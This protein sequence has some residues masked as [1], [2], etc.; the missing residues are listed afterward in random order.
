M[1]LP[2]PVC[3][4]ENG[5]K[6]PD[7]PCSL[8]CDQCNELHARLKKSIFDNHDCKILFKEMWKHIDVVHW[9]K[10][11]RSHV[12]NGKHLGAWAFTLTKSPSDD[13]SEDDMVR[14]VRKLMSQKSCPVKT[15]AWY[16]EYGDPE[17]KSHPHIHGMYETH[18]GGRI[19]RKHFFRAWNIW[20]ED[21]PLG[22]GFRGGYHREV[23][24]DERYADYIK[25]PEGKFADT[26]KDTNVQ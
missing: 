3:G 7:V 16:L 1:E 21:I 24:H 17:T 10:K 19:E 2:C 15:Y 20:N 6:F 4:V 12:G 25:K 23:K 18:T 11:P 8:C 5:S 22:K 26:P 9:R 13:L 14:A